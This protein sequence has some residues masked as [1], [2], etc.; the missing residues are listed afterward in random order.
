MFFCYKELQFVKIPQIPI[1]HFFS[2]LGILNWIAAACFSLL[3]SA[4]IFLFIYISVFYF[5]FYSCAPIL[6]SVHRFFVFYV[7]T[8]G[9]S[10]SFFFCL[11][12]T[13]KR[14]SQVADRDAKSTS[15][16]SS[17]SSRRWAACLCAFSLWLGLAKDASAC[18]RVW[19]C[20]SVFA[21][22]PVCLG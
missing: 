12:Y 19:V 18:L 10:V 5:C 21:C 9:A 1:Q 11:L 7:I 13:C 3:T 15:S 22:L 8:G 6:F 16:S 14:L 20:A 2:F 17:S 4:C